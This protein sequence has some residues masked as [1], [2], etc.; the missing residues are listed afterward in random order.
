MFCKQGQKCQW[1]G[2]GDIGKG[3]GKGKQEKKGQKCH[4][5]KERPSLFDRQKVQDDEFIYN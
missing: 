1:S 4:T 5:R 3:K 2:V